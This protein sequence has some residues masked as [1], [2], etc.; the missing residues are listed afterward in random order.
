VVG[1]VG[2]ADDRGLGSLKLMR[3]IWELR[4]QLAAQLEREGRPLPIVR[5]PSRRWTLRKYASQ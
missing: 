1:F 4:G 2:T 5:P 3:L